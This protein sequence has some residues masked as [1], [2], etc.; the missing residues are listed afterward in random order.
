[1]SGLGQNVLLGVLEDNPG[2]YAGEP[3]FR[4]VRVVFSKNGSNWETF[5]SDCPDPACLKAIVS[6]YPREMTWTVGF[7]GRKIGQVTSVAPATFDWYASV[8]QESVTDTIVPTVGQKSEEFG[9]FIHRP[10]FR[11]LVADSQPYFEDPDAWKPAR[12]SIDTIALLRDQFRKKFPSVTNCVSPDENVPRPWK[13]KEDNIKVLKSYASRQKWAIAQL[14]LDPCRCDGWPDD[15]FLDYWFAISPQ[16]VVR[17]LDGGMWL[18]DAGNYDN[19]GRSEL[20]FSI[21]RDE[22]GGYELFYDD[23]KKHVTFEFFYH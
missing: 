4:A 6:K 20:L 14:R 9:G 10:V 2:R 17:V 16:G 7:D 1:L 3:N 11:P 22:G 23:F 13:Y 12:L 5:P 21:D 18:V 8:G 15:S 19:D